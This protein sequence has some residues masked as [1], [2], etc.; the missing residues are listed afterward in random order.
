MVFAIGTTEIHV[1]VLSA[2]VSSGP[3]G[4]AR[5]CVASC[6]GKILIPYTVNAMRESKATITHL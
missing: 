2:V 1:K 4:P 5:E 3:S 6:S